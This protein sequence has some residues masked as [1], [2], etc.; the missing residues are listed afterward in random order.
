MANQ[1]R[2]KLQEEEEE[3]YNTINSQAFRDGDPRI[4]MHFGMH[5]ERAR[6]CDGSYEA[7]NSGSWSRDS[8]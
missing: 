5:L 7:K 6:P 4:A 3:Y 2:L 1:L 8:E